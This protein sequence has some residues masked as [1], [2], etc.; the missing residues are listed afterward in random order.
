MPKLEMSQKVLALSH[1][2]CGESPGNRPIIQIK[3][4]ILAASKPNR[5]A[6]RHTDTLLACIGVTVKKMIP[7]LAPVVVLAAGGGIY[8][9]LH[10]A[11]PEPEKKEDPVRPL[12][13][14]VEPVE[15]SSVV[16]SVETGGE[17]RARTE[18]DI[19]AQVSGRVV[20]VSSEFTEGGI[21]KPDTV[22]V[23]IEDTDYQ[24]ALLQAEA[25]VADAEVGVQQALA[26]QD[27]AKK[28]LR[29]S[30]N[31]SDLALKRP[32]VAQARARLKAAEASLA[33][34]RMNLERTAITLP[35][36]GR[37]VDTQVDVGQ[38]I[39]P[40]TPIGR[41]FA[42]DVVEV[43]LPLNDNQLASLDLPIGYVANDD[44][45]S[46]ELSA[47]VGGRTQFWSANLKRLDAAIESETRMIYG[48]AELHAP[49]TQNL[50]QLGMPLAVGL[51]VNARIDGRELEDAYVIPRDALRAGNQVF[52]VNNDGRL[53]VRGV[54][55]KHSSPQRAVIAAGLKQA[56]RVV[57]SS[58]RNP[59]EGM[60]LE[61]LE[62]TYRGT[63]V[64]GQ[65]A[66]SG[67]AGE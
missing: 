29:G 26:D 3:R 23:S 15:K 27:V 14:F 33:Q 1:R 48:I 32:Q 17:V 64:R 37:I 28:Q 10:W 2:Y 20:S 22:L 50:S 56:E 18:I 30:N 63:A 40:G 60:A 43:R 16:L 61:A 36:D 55:V 67:H 12:S 21:V 47:V 57:V 8:A 9:L 66:D 6:K 4:P 45:L 31:V 24:L 53:E 39:T 52:V 35:F 51:Y 42:T 65:V 58:I 49:Y 7:F 44:G 13:V 54:E 41:A 19:V 59:I 11:K 34:A 46:V 38:F 5:E 25:A 62:N